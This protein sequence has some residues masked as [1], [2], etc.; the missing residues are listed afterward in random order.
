MF[1]FIVWNRASNYPELSDPV[2]LAV[3]EDWVNGKD[4]VSDDVD[5]SSL[6]PPCAFLSR[7]SVDETE[8]LGTGKSF[9]CSFHIICRSYLI[10]C[11]ITCVFYLTWQALMMMKFWIRK[12]IEN[13]ILLRI[14]LFI[15]IIIMLERSRDLSY[16]ASVDWPH[17]RYPSD[18]LSWSISFHVLFGLRFSLSL[19]L[20]IADVEVCVC[21]SQSMV[22]YSTN[23][24]TLYKFCWLYGEQL[25][26]MRRKYGFFP[27]QIWP[28]F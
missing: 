27:L 16:S 8:E 22:M 19:S 7:S 2:A 25:H 18:W 13:R 15:M 3:V 1:S 14:I 20:Y 10:F 12:K 23:C 26:W 17:S 28:I 4:K 5:W 9:V 11:G 21:Q 6:Y 24:G